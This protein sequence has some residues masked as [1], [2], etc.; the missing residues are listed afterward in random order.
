MEYQLTQRNEGFQA[1]VDFERLHKT[2]LLIDDDP[3]FR[4]L[5]SAVLDSAVVSVEAFESIADIGSFAKI[6]TYDIAIIDCQ[7]PVMRGVEIA[8][9]IDTFFDDMPVV[10][11]SA[12]QSLGHYKKQDLPRCIRDFIAKEEGI[13]ALVNTVMDLVHA[14]WL[15]PKHCWQP[16]QF[17]NQATGRGLQ[18]N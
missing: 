6:G 14:S 2:I 15:H 5:V 8:Q 10:L 1:D 11:V 9:Y 17:K 3:D 16:Q 7:L 18:W 13:G 4:D 12:D